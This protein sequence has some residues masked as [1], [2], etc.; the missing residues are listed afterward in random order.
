M[1]HGSTPA[2]PELT[3]RAIGVKPK[4]L[5]ACSEAKILAAAPSFKPEALPAVTV[6]SALKA[7]RNFD[8]ISIVVLFF[9]NS[10]VSKMIDSPLRCGIITGTISFAKRPFA[11][12]TAVFCCDHTENLS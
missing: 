10:S 9:G 2:T 5:I 11:C 3:I 7:G 4:S 8:K 12:A 1:I 6:P